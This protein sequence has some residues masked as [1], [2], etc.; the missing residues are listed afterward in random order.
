MSALTHLHGVTPHESDDS[1]QQQPWFHAE[2]E[3]RSHFTEFW[4][5]GRVAPAPGA[6]WEVM[7]V[8][9]G[10]NEMCHVTLHGHFLVSTPPL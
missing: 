4:Y 1:S 7:E 8:T 9:V 3:I 10:E 6:S 2:E 5:G